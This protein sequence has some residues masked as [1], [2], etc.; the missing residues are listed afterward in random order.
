MV[1]VFF[2]S[3]Y[4]LDAS[5]NNIPEISTLFISMIQYTYDCVNQHLH[6]NA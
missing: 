1:N 3:H 5:H 4:I 6:E 2:I